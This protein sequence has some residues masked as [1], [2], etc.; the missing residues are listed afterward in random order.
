[1]PM[2]ILVKNVENYEWNA[3]LEMYFPPS[4]EGHA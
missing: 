1:M 3:T 4:C 2:G